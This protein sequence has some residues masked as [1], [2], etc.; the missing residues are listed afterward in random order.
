M[1]RTFRLA[2]QRRPPLSRE[3]IDTAQADKNTYVV[4]MNYDITACNFASTM[5]VSKLCRE[6]LKPLKAVADIP[7]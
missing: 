3:V 5:G 4:S 2:V 7:R 1:N 6:I